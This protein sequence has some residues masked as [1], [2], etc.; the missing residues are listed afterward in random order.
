MTKPKHLRSIRHASE[1]E[2]GGLALLVYILC[3][4]TTTILPSSQHNPDVLRP[5][6]LQRPTTEQAR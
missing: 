4:L 3:A 5:S 2:Q 6:F 1:A